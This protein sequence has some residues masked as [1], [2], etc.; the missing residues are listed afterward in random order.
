MTSSATRRCAEP[1]VREF[2]RRCRDPLDTG[3][4]GG[5]PVSRR[6]GAWAARPLAAL[7]GHPFRRFPMR[8]P[9]TC[10]VLLPLAVATLA[11]LAA[12]C[13]EA[14]TATGRAIELRASRAAGGAAVARPWKGR[15]DV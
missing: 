5:G 3:L 13:T 1:L 8:T 10:A 2:P 7:T 11:M 12:A 14:P 9:T 6:L 15:C 4:L